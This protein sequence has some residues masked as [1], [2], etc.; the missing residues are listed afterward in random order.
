MTLM[1]AKLLPGGRGNLYALTLGGTAGA[2]VT[3]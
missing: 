2:G 1:L 3:R